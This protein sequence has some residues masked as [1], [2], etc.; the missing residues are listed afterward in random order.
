MKNKPYDKFWLGLLVGTA[1]PIVAYAL[2]LMLLEVLDAYDIV[3]YFNP[4]TTMLL[5]LCSDLVPFQWFK[6]R[7][8]DQAMRG[9]TI[10]VLVFAGL[11][12]YKNKYLL[13][14]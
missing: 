10:P 7:R 5:A 8:Y 4:R 2:L 9:M 6:R 12:L 3:E 1:V 13:G 11:W 14:L